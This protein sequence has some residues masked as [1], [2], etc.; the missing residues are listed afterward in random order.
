M[1]LGT[2][3]PDFLAAHFGGFNG[4]VVRIVENQEEVATT[5][6]THNL[7]E[8]DLL[9]AMLEAMLEESKPGSLDFDRD[10]LITTTFRYPPLRHGSRFGRRGEASLMYASLELETCLQEC[11]YYRFKFY[12]DMSTPPRR[13]I[14]SQHTVFWV[15]L[16][17]LSC[18]DLRAAVF[19]VFQSE[20]RSPVSYR[21]SQNLGTALRT[22]GADMLVAQSA[23][24][25][26]SNTGV[27]TAKVIH[28]DPKHKQHW[29]SQTTAEQV[30]LR[31][32][33]GLYPFPVRRF[34]GSD[35]VFQQ[36]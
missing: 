19:K 10:Y 4:D 36:V 32:N 21:F 7:E 20:L 28:G 8:A 33:R 23:R 22:A 5:R 11:A 1:T 18:V 27:F 12:F 2:P 3:S 29:I 31:S 6:I 17:S 25:K 14:D 9:E 15:S 35:G 34:A 24:G 16:H 13:P 30:V 26:G